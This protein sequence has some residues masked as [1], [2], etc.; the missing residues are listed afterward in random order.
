[1]DEL[2]TYLA[3]LDEAERTALALK[4]GF[5]LGHIKNVSYGCKPCDH[6]LA[7][8][9]EK[10]TNGRVT[11]K[12]LCPNDWDMVWLELVTADTDKKTATAEA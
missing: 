2:K 12:G 3:E 4:C 11:R 6:K 7:A 5:S 1:M 8:A 9:L 10:N